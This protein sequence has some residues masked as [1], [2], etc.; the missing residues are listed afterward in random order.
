MWHFL[1]VDVLDGGADTGS[2]ER[3]EQE[4]H[5]IALDE[6]PGLLH[7][8]GR[9]VSIV[10]GNEIDLA[11]VDATALVDRIDVGDQTLPG[12][13]ERRRGT[14]KRERRPHLHFGAG[15]AGRFRTRG[16][17]CN[18]R[19]DSGCQ[20]G[21]PKHRLLP[22]PAT[23]ASLTIRSNSSCQPAA[24][25]LDAFAS[26]RSIAISRSWCLSILPVEAEGRAS[27]TI[28][29]VGRLYEVSCWAAYAF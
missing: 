23:V 18:R 9:A 25:A 7:R 21:F 26:P 24:A 20:Y 6:L 19:A 3:A 15:D 10:V 17:A 29:S 14:A 1:R 28:S 8:L 16:R 22:C 12:V 11:A 4:S 27:S 5:F 13:A 2:T